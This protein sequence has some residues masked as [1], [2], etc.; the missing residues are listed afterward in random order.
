[1]DTAVSV[2]PWHGMS[3]RQQAV[4]ASAFAHAH[5]RSHE[6]HECVRM[7]E[8]AVLALRTQAIAEDALPPESELARSNIV[9]DLDDFIPWYRVA[10]EAAYGHQPRFHPPTHDECVAAFERYRCG[11]ADFY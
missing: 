2:Q 11:R 4:W 3:P 5:A 1:M 7:A 8:R 9:V 6:V 10:A